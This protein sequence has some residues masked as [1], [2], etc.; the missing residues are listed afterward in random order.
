MN[1]NPRTLCYVHLPFCDRICPYCDFA[2][3]RFARPGVDRYMRALRS[4]LGRTAR[5][6]GGIS[7]LYLGGGT[8][9]ALGGDR[10]RALLEAIFTRFEITPGN[11]E[12]TLEAN[13]SRN[14]ED[15]RR[16]REAGVNR[17][18]IG[19]QSFDD[20]E[21]QRLGRD[22]NADEA[23]RYVAAARA[24]GFG[25]CSIDLIAGAPG[26]TRASF[27]KSLDRALE[28]ASDHISV[29]ALT[30]ET[31]TPYAQWHARSPGA[32]PPDD[33]VADLL[34]MTDVKL[35]AAGMEHYEISNF[36]RPGFECAHNTGY[37]D[38]RDC[39][40]FGMSAAG[41][42]GGTRYRN[43]RGFE[44]YCAAIEAGRSPRAEEEQ[45]DL[46]GRIGEAAML[47]LRTARGIRDA[48]FHQRFGV[49]TRAIFATAIKECREAGLL[50]ETREGVRLSARGRLLANTACLEFLHPALFP[51]PTAIGIRTS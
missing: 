45:L 5:P 39:I 43:L 41:Y 47:A 21:L 18:S 25:N 40:A 28:C 22:H 10:I 16:Y 51:A 8:P 14:I 17:L 30:I 37:W 19:V 36:A 4:E 26:Q 2:V 48:D 38:Q 50:E 23:V 35:T 7:S 3:V 15:L 11:V 6:A 46:A 20:G 42:E 34:E 49:E 32:F 29:Y 24:A 27:E 1:R 44:D 13:P 31:G 12:C 33:D 9:S